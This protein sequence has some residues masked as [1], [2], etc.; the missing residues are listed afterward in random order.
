MDRK[1]PS[2]GIDRQGV[3]LLLIVVIIGSVLVGAALWAA[4]R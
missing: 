2:L 4:L 1:R 3:A